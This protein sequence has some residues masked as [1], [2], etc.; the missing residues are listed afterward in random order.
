VQPEAV[1]DSCVTVMLG[2][3]EIY[4]TFHQVVPTVISVE[5][6]EQTLELWEHLA[7]N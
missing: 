2:A 4:G 5:Y 1:V 6:L 3:V 7:E